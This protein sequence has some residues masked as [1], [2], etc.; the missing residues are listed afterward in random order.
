MLSVRVGDQSIFSNLDDL[1]TPY[2]VKALQITKNQILRGFTFVKTKASDLFTDGQ[3][4]DRVQKRLSSPLRNRFGHQTY[5]FK[6]KE[7][8]LNRLSN[9]LQKR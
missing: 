5:G 3:A 8:M 9:S 7:E 6:E 2:S 4:V 1:V